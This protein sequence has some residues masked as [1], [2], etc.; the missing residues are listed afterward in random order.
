V[1]CDQLDA[2][3]QMLNWIAFGLDFSERLF[4]GLRSVAEDK[5]I[6]EKIFSV[7]PPGT[8]ENV[9]FVIGESMKVADAVW[10]G[11]EA[12][13]RAAVGIAVDIAAFAKQRQFDRYQQFYQGDVNTQPRFKEAVA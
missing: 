10:R 6:P 1:A 3:V 5:A 9:K 12:W 13:F 8:N 7:L 4:V 11:P 2:A